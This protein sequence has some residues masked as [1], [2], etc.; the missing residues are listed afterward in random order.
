MNESGFAATVETTSVHPM[1]KAWFIAIVPLMDTES[2]M[3]N[4]LNIG[5]DDG[6]KKENL[7]G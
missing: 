6:K 1:K 4:A 5:A 7:K 2:A 3:L